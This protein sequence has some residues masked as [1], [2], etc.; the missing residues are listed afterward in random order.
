MQREASI[1]RPQPHD[2]SGRDVTARPI[3]PF[4]PE[5]R[6]RYDQE[7]R[8][9]TRYRSDSSDFDISED[10]TDGV[11]ALGPI[12]WTVQVTARDERRGRER[13]RVY[14]TQ[15]PLASGNSRRQKDAPMGPLEE[16]AEQGKAENYEPP[17]WGK[18]IFQVDCQVKAPHLPDRIDA[19]EALVIEQVPDNRISTRSPFLVQRLRAIADYYPD[20]FRQHTDNKRRGLGRTVSFPETWGF[21]LHRF[22]AMETFLQSKDDESSTDRERDILAL[23]REHTQILYN[24]LKP[25]YENIV[26]PC[27]KTLDASTPRISFEDLWYIFPPGTD[28]Y[29]RNGPAFQV[30]VVY[31][32]LRQFDEPRAES[33]RR[34]GGVALGDQKS[35]TFRVWYLTTDGHFMRRTPGEHK[36]YHFEG[37]L[38]VTTLTMCPVSYWDKIDG[39]ER[40]R[41]IIQRSTMLSKSYREGHLLAHYN[42]PCAGATASYSG[43]L[44]VDHRRGL[45][46]NEAISR[47]QEEFLEY[48]AQPFGDYDNILIHEGAEDAGRIETDDDSDYY[49]RDRPR[50]RRGTTVV[51]RS[52][53]EI[54]YS[55]PFRSATFRQSDDGGRNGTMAKGS[56]PRELSEHQLLL[57][58]PLAWAF[59]LK[60]KQW[61]KGEIQTIR[62]LA[63]RQNSTKEVWA[64]DFI[65]GKGTGQIAL[66]HGPPGVGKTYT[67]EA[68]AEFLHRPLL[69]L[70]VADIGTQETKVERELF[71]WFS[72]A[73]AWNA[74]LLVDEADIFLERRQNRDLARNGLVSAFLRRMEYFKGL[75][76]L[77]T[78]RVGQ[79][80]DAF[81]SRVHVAI[82][83][84][85][86]TSQ[87][88]VKIW[89]GFFHKLDKE[90]A[91]KIQIA[92]GAKKWVLEKAESGG[93]QLNGRDIRN[94][95]QT[96]ITLAE[97]EYEEDPD[98]DP[99]NTTIVVDQSHFERVLEISEKFHSYLKSI[100]KED[101]KKRAAVRYDRNDFH[102]GP[103]RDSSAYPDD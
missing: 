11:E 64:A 88:R 30:A 32:T 31:D 80:D 85:P 91:G 49:S 8:E 60:T 46:E 14:K 20:F 21:L 23:E 75:L 83:Y 7:E 34:R 28:V 82:G 3:F 27:M 100:R 38:D 24:Y 99:E 2:V 58:R 93:A 22:R 65:E 72:L 12:L 97:A 39:G 5:S 37:L 19:V 53:E 68:I 71:K 26:V 92:R 81:I 29:F 94:A 61:Y 43:K 73:E 1:E 33:R 41:K 13:I 55:S 102:G 48:W 63:T 84:R 69:A 6:R 57:I 98:F 42:G 51:R 101:E 79:I 17:S 77:T 47:R 103:I 87:D 95:L 18:V 67:V 86:F 10:D 78:N 96:A 25:H 36:I 40:R 70:T 52:E 62:A 9:I 35:W 76:F 45:L 74:V 59:A 90:R 50:R 44:V 54:R 56:K 66:L 4:A 15:S 89:Q 16:P